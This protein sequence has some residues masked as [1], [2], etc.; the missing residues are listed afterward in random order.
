MSS[1]IVAPSA[2]APAQAGLD[3]A[4]ASI[5]ATIAADFA[6][7]GV[8]GLSIGVVSG[9]QLIWSKHYGYAGSLPP[10]EPQ[11]EEDSL[12]RRLAGGARA[13][14]GAPLAT[15]ARSGADAHQ[16]RRL[17]QSLGGVRVVKTYTAERCEDL[18]FTKGAHRLLRNIAKSMLEI[19]YWM[20]LNRTTHTREIKRLEIQVA[21]L[22]DRIG[23]P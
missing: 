23:R 19:W 3:A 10:P 22:V 14:L 12:V 5:D 13:D 2:Q 11:K 8:G 6:K 9:K 18:V 1:A 20:D 4:I 17:N 15:V 21:K 16:P 7:D